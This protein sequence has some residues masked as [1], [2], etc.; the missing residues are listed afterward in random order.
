VWV[1]ARHVTTDGD[2]TRAARTR[3]NMTVM[4]QAMQDTIAVQAADSTGGA[5]IER[6]RQMLDSVTTQNPPVPDPIAAALQSVFG[7]P[8]WVQITAVVIG[9]IAA[10]VLL[11]FLWKRRQAL[12][13]WLT[14]RS[15]GA[16]IA[17]A[18]S[19]ALV[20][21]AVAGVGL[22]GFHYMEHDNDFCTGCHV[23]APSIDRFSSSEHA[24]LECHDCHQQSMYANARQLFL[25][26][27]DRPEDI[28][29]HAPVPTRIC[30]ECHIQEQPDSVWQ[31]ISATA[32]HRLHLNSDSLQKAGIQCVT[33]HGLEVHRFAP[34]DST[35]GQSQCHDN[36]TVRLGKMRAQS[37]LH[38][39]SCHEFTV[40]VSETVSTDSLMNVLVPR[41][42]QCFA[43]H[44]MR[45]AI[46]S[47]NV[48]IEPHGAVC[49]TCHNPHEQET[50]AAAFETCATGGCHA[51][52]DTLSP[53]HRGIPASALDDCGSC[54]QAHD[55]QLEGAQCLSCHRDIFDERGGRRGG[56]AAMLPGAPPA[57]PA[58][59]GAAPRRTAPPVVHLT[60][61]QGTP[62]GAPAPPR[63]PAPA[64]GLGYA[65]PENFSHREHREVECTDCHNSRERHGALIVRT[66]RDCQECHH[67]PARVAA[68][69]APGRI[70]CAACHQ[71]SEIAG[72]EAVAARMELGVWREARERRLPFRHDWHRE[73]SC[74]DCHT[75]PLTMAATRGCADC[76]DEHHEPDNQCRACHVGA[77]A[78]A[79][80]EEHEQEAHL[81]CTGSGCHEAR[82]VSSLR[83]TRAVCESCHQDMVNHR[84]GRE[85]SRCHQVQW[86]QGARTGGTE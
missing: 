35:C 61:A 27:V 29:K 72:Q 39:V 42:E 52:A 34:V 11:V 31:R 71:P 5:T 1:D 64:Q 73:V 19:A 66:A 46:R 13:A 82:T 55:W 43:C 14:T 36:L 54:H 3:E 62:Q 6:Q 63:A 83:E 85:C 15:R 78:T 70:A 10:V 81:G 40:P 23:M 75:Q 37:D 2:P 12:W 17:L 8:S 56:R 26:I 74:T 32:G 24:Q 67:D 44:E 86:L 33:C 79:V 30:A 25:W 60:M 53:F 20:L 68:A 51:R 80:K 49:G 28:G 47:I 16:K 57:Y 22:Y 9:A 76:H 7:L 38:C 65:G 18:S 84:P 41:Q 69:P 59:H 21:V 4:L 45:Q 48:E 50:P 77:T 58:T